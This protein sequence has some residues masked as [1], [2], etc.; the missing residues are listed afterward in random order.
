V[1]DFVADAL[2]TDGA[3]ASPN[4]IAAKRSVGVA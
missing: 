2:A 4:P 3:D 1:F